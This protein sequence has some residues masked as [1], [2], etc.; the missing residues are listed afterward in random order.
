MKDGVNLYPFQKVGHSFIKQ[1]KWVLV[2][3]SMGLGKSIQAIS[4]FEKGV[5]ALVICPAMLKTNWCHE[6]NKFTDLSVKSVDSKYDYTSIPDVIVSSYENVKHI[7]VDVL[8]KI[9]VLDESHFIK[10]MKAKRTQNVHKYIAAVIPEYL[11][12]LSGTPITKSCIEFY[13]ILKL[14]SMC[15]SGTNGI[16]LSAKSQYAFNMRFS[17]Q[18]TRR[19]NVKSRGGDTRSVQVQEFKGIK[20]K[21]ELKSIL[22]GKFLRRLASKVL[23]LPKL[24]EKELIL[25]RKKTKR[26]SYLFQM[27]ESNPDGDDHFIKLKIEAAVEK[28]PHTLKYVESI[29][30]SGEQ[31]VLFTDHLDSASALLSGL[32][33]LKISCGEVSGRRKRIER[34]N[35]IADFSNRKIKVLVCTFSAASV[36]LTLTSASQ[37]VLND[38]SY[39]C[40]M[41]LQAK[42]RI[43]RISQ[44]RPCVITTMINGDFDYKIKRRLDEK[45]KDISEIVS[46]DI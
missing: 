38:L 10:N 4:V 18:S 21:E 19:I 14:L 39:R 6:I 43:H 36:G 13:S 22:R 15:P 41:I 17:H 25:S 42:K 45:I 12:A 8:P 44:K 33:E 5:Q 16:P 32:R 35:S 9:I 3:D 37:M 2:G 26:D 46:K 24:T 23:D 20:N 34:D 29:V 27:M 7:P 28:V 40:D 30:D 31:V 11:I 1:K